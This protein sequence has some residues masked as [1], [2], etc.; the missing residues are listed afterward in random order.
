MAFLDLTGLSRFLDKLKTIFALDSDVVHKTGNEEINGIKTFKHDIHL[1]EDSPSITAKVTNTVKGTP[2]NSSLYNSISWFDGSGTVSNATRYSSIG[3]TLYTSGTISTRILAF[4]NEVGNSEYAELSVNYPLNRSA[5]ATAPSTPITGT[6]NDIITRDYLDTKNYAKK[7]EWSSTYIYYITLAEE[8]RWYQ[9]LN[10][11]KTI[12]VTQY[13]N[14]NCYGVC[15]WMLVPAATVAGTLIQRVT[16]SDGTEYTYGI[17]NAIYTAARYST[18]HIEN[19]R[20]KVT[21]YSVLSTANSTTSTQQTRPITT[22]VDSDAY[23]TQVEV[24]M[25]TSGSVLPVGTKLRIYTLN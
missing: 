23:I 5:Y 18:V 25:T 12:D 13:T 19:D 4:K 20:G 21:A 1:E 24:Y 16:F 11:I 14:N 17:S 15:I 9:S 2:P 3:N 10:T 8:E 6:A 7:R 22:F